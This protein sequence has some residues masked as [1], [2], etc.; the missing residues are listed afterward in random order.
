MHSI[1]DDKTKRADSLINNLFVPPRDISQQSWKLPSPPTVESSGLNR[2]RI[3]TLKEGY[4]FVSNES[5]GRDLF[6]FWTDLIDCDFNSLKAGDQLEYCIGRNE[7]GDCAK[8]IRR[9]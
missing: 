8:E 1:I 9:L 6:F 2:G 4:G 7:K 3:V 5:L